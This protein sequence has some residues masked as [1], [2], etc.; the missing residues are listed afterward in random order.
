[1]FVRQPRVRLKG[2]IA[3]TGFASGDRFVVGLWDDGPLGPMIDVMWARPDGRRVL[4]A[5]DQR[6]ARF[7]GGIYEFDEVQVAP[8]THRR[9]GNTLH[10]KADDVR[11]ALRGGRPNRIFNLRP[12]FL[13]RSP[14]WVRIEDLVFRPLVGRFVLRGAGSVRAYGRTKSGLREWY[15]VD[16]YRSLIAATGTVGGRDL[17][18]MRP[19]DPPVRFG[20]SEF[21]RVPALVDC[22]PLLEG[23]LLQ[24]LVT[25]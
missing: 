24:E 10:V 23:Q 11:L 17:G 25:S 4:L 18:D 22:A 3:A 16:A 12:K 14:L 6:V 13:R 1:M 19:L 15:C 9:D 5:P 7:V 21:P 8:M 20:F 2:T